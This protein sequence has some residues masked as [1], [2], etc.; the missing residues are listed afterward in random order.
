MD[1]Q[2]LTPTELDELLHS[3]NSQGLHSIDSL[4]LDKELTARD[5]DY[6]PGEDDYDYDYDY[7]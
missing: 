6:Y 2:D 7:E 4:E 3:I 1:F 5:F